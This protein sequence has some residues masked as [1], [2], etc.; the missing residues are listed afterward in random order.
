[1][2]HILLALTVLILF[3]CMGRNM[4][5]K[6]TEFYDVSGKVNHLTI[7]HYNAVEK[8]GEIVKGEPNRLGDEDQTLTFNKHGYVTQAYFYREADSLDT[9]LLRDHDENFRC[10]GEVGYNANGEQ[11]FE[12]VWLYNDKGNNTERIHIQEDGSLFVS[13]YL[14]YDEN[15]ELISRIIY[16]DPNSGDFDSLLWV[17]DDKNRQLEEWYYGY[18]GLEGYSKM[19]YI[20]ETE[21]IST[22]YSYDLH[23]ELSNFFTLTYNDH[24]LLS[25]VKQFDTDSLEQLILNF[26]YEYDKR[27]NWIKKI[28]FHDG[29]PI[30]YDIRKIIYY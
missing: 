16:N 14:Y 26:E 8:D 4:P 10:L 21:L 18:W 7:Y 6:D 12:W 23:E 25:E 29:T 5:Q 2:K 19:E 9:K 24:D 27:G 11:V 3:S 20:G 28:R 22:I 30:N 1:M 15:N 17:L 13:W